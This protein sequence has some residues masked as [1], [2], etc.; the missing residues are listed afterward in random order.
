[1]YE[2]RIKKSE[3]EKILLNLDTDEGIRI[4]SKD[5]HKK[6]FINKNLLGVFIVLIKK[7]KTDNNKDYA[8]QIQKCTFFHYT[9]IHDL[10]DYINNNI[11]NYNIWLY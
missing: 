3:L 8:S 4:E 6:I 7:D 11:S 10:M 1:M 2:K 5:M 9:N